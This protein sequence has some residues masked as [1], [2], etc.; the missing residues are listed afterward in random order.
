MRSTLSP[1]FTGSKIRQMFELVNDVGEEAMKGMKLEVDKGSG[2]FEFK[3][4]AM[5]F[6]VDIIASCAFGLEV[7]SFKHSE[8]EFYT[9]A[10]KIT[11]QT[12]NVK[13]ILR[14][15]GFMIAPKVM[16]FL[17]FTLMDK[18][19][20]QYLRKAI[21]DTMKFREEKKIARQDMINLLMKAKKGQLKHGDDEEEKNEG[22]A[23]VEESQVGKSEVKRTWNDNEL[24]AQALIF[25]FG[26]K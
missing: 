19:D 7:D 1:A 9:M 5:K 20:M 24:F 18:N 2:E 25:F 3:A 14:S 4:L 21:I 8:N 22:F 26:E 13:D 17:G 15:F 23:T 10:M 16:K 12:L 6:A 11:G